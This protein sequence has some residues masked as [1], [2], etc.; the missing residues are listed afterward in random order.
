MPKNHT[1]WE[2]FLLL[3]AL[4]AVA[5]RTGTFPALPIPPPVLAGL[6]MMG[7]VP[8]SLAP[9]ELPSELPLS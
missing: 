8:D 2:A 9:A 6:S 7:D 5:E 3:Q 1:R 4:C